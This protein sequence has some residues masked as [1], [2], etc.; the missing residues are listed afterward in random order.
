MKASTL[1]SFVAL[2]VAANAQGASYTRSSSL[3]GQAFLNAF[4]WQAIADP[5]NG[6]VYALQSASRI[7]C[8]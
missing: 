7:V 6:R 8:V 2:A 3:S 5:T 4:E 1:L